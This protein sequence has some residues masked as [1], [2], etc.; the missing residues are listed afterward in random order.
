MGSGEGR[1]E[2]SRG[3]VRCEEWSNPQAPG[4]GSRVAGRGLRA[5]GYVLRFSRDSSHSFQSNACEHIPSRLEQPA[6]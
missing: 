5:A 6:R 1:C 2:V 3:E 4:Y